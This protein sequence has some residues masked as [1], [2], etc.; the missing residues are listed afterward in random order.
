[1]TNDYKLGYI[2]ARNANREIELDDKT[3]GIYRWIYAIHARRGQ[4]AWKP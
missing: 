3:P 2:A 1:M 4:L